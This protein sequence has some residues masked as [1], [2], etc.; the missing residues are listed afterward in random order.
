MKRIGAFF[1]SMAGRIFLI[2]LVGVTLSASLAYGIAET[3]RYGDLWKLDIARA[4]DRVEDVVASWRALPAGER[5][6]FQIPRLRGVE[7]VTPDIQVGGGETFLEQQLAA[8]LPGLTVQARRTTPESC[9]VDTGGRGGFDGRGGP[10]RAS[11][12]SGPPD[13][14]GP[15]PGANPAANPGG[16]PGG[17]IVRRCWLVTV[18]DGAHSLQMVAETQPRPR[19]QPLVFDPLYLNVLWIAAAGMA[20]WVARIA[21]RPLLA[22]SRA[23]TDLGGDLTRSPLPLTGPTELRNAAGAFNAMQV[24]LQRQMAERTHM[25]AAI[26]HDLQ[27]PVTRL[28]LRLEKVDDPELRE[29]LLGDLGAMQ[30]LIREG[31]DLARST[32]HAEDRMTL[33][34]Q[35]LVDSLVDD[36]AD[37]GQAVSGN[38]RCDGLDVSVQPEAMRRVLSNLIDNALKY[39]GSAEVSVARDGA[40]AVVRV[41]DHGPGVPADQLES[42]FDPFVRL[43]DSRSRETG[44]AGLGLTIARTLAARSG[45]EITL[46]N[47]PGGGAEATLRFSRAA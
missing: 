34:L 36:A 25:L 37:A 26:T 33:D 41:R 44:G 38:G 1:A 45:A 16:N 32:E 28:R 31:L 11:D 20:F 47:H 30:T 35:S 15:P 40:G 5:D 7:P 9:R 43:E 8:R 3:K 24:Q 22:L 29:R 10:D 42:V 18:K 23:A 4:V 6:A 19:G 39:G 21:A 17:D 12:H 14:H 46:V 27:T 2:L 13:N